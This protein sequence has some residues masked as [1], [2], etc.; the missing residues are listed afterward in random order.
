MANTTTTPYIVPIK[1]TRNLL[2]PKFEGYKL[3]LFDEQVGLI[4]VP[5]PQPSI[6]VPKVPLHEKLSYKEIRSRVHYNH[7]FAGYD[8]CE[9]HGIAYYFDSDF[10]IVL[11]E[12]DLVSL[13]QT[14]FYNTILLTA[15]VHDIRRR[16]L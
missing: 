5:L 10:R 15:K 7:L 11:V 13:L 4:S 2:N 12:Y 16:S 1:P 3:E 8:T 14:L 9:G 6:A